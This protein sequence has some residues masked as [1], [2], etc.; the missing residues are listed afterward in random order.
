MWKSRKFIITGIVIAALL[1]VGTAGIVLA[2]Q[3]EGQD[4]T[5]GSALLTRVAEILGVDQQK[6]E[7]AFKRARTEL[8][9]EALDKRLKNLVDEDEITQEQADQY[10][11]WIQAKPDIPRV[12]PRQLKA[13][14]EDGVITQ[15]QM[16]GY[17]KEYKEWREAKPDVP[18]PSHQKPRWRPGFRLG[19]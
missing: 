1:I 6:L 19:F 12:G 17:L 18:L 3:D 10:K 2:Q 11:A 7:D 16:D 8:Q 5:Q 15:E 14:V 9:E 4:K 13:L